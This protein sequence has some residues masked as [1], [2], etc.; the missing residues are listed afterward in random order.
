LAADALTVSVSAGRLPC[1]G[2]KWQADH[3]GTNMG[4][5]ADILVLLA[6]VI[7]SYLCA[8]ALSSVVITTLR[9]SGPAAMI[10]G[11]VLFAAVF[12]TILQILQ[13]YT[14][15]GLFRFDDA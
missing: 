4:S 14:G 7:V 15:I 5:A 10:T 13:R 11:M 6:G 9:L 8:G 1:A 2:D 3:Y 12:F